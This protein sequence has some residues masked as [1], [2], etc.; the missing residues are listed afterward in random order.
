[1]QYAALYRLV[2]APP[3]H[4]STWQRYKVIRAR[5]I[6]LGFGFGRVTTGHWARYNMIRRSSRSGARQMEDA[7]KRQ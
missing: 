2:F 1:M 4:R 3:K 6:R 7:S 5:G